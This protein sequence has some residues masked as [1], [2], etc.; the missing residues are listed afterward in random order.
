VE[1]FDD[2]PTVHFGSDVAQEAVQQWFRS[3]LLGNSLDL[4][5]QLVDDTNL[6]RGYVHPHFVMFP[7]KN[8]IAVEQPR[9]TRISL[10][11]KL[12]SL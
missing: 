12:L 11:I 4:F 8:E 6:L 5:V 10:T 9:H 7:I 3:E 1:F 2:A